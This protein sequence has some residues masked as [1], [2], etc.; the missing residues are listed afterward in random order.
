M[1]HAENMGSGEASEHMLAVTTMLALVKLNT[2]KHTHTSLAPVPHRACTISSTVCVVGARF[3]I[4]KHLKPDCVGCHNL[5]PSRHKLAAY[6]YVLHSIWQ[7]KI[8]CD[9]HA[10][11][12][13]CT[14]RQNNIILHDTAGLGYPR[15]YHR[16]CLSLYKVLLCMQ[17]SSCHPP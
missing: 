5:P 10:H 2:T 16:E 9:Q 13:R 17:A 4:H 8:C 7:V 12:C 1:R 14:G 15:V 6:G 11:L 3:C